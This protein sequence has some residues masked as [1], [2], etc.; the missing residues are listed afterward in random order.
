MVSGNEEIAENLNHEDWGD[1]RTL[2]V[3]SSLGKLIGDP[4]INAASTFL[5]VGLI[6]PLVAEGG[7]LPWFEFSGRLGW[8]V[9]ERRPSISASKRGR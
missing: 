6:G 4:L 1:I 3:V 2:W 5:R 9:H 8:W 7:R